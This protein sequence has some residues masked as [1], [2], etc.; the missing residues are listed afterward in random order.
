M[1]ELTVDCFPRQNNGNIFSGPKISFEIHDRPSAANAC[2]PYNNFHL[3]CM[4]RKSI[5]CRAPSVG[6]KS[7]YDISF[8]CI[9][10]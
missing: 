10:C 6:A 1:T 5:E 9:A 2:K 3:V 8:L 7:D 4:K